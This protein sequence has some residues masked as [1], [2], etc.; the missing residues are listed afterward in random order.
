M[1]KILFLPHQ[2]EIQVK[3]KEV[4]LRAAME[5]GVHINAS[6]GGAGVCGK[7]R[8]L[9]EEGQV[10]GGISEKLSKEDLEKGYRQACLA[11]VVSDLV[12]RVPVESAIDAEVLNLAAVPRKTARIQEMNLD[13]LKEK[14]LF[15]PPVEKKYLELIPPSA[16]DNLPDTTRLLSFLKLVHD[17]HRLEVDLS[18]L[19]KIPDV[20]REQDFKVTAVLAR[21]VREKD[22]RTRIINVQPGD[23]TDHNYAIAM[24]IGTTTIYGQLLNLRTGD[25]LAQYGDFNGQISYGEDVISRIVYAEKPGG[26]EKLHQVVIETVNKIIL[27][28]FRHAR[29]DTEAVSTITLAG[30]TTMTQLFL[31]IN[32]RYIRRSPYVPASTLFPPIR[33]VDLGLA[34]GD[35]VTALFYP[36]LS[37]YVGGDIV[38]GVMGSGMYRSEALALFMDIGTNA[39]IV[40]GNKDWLACAACSAGP[41]FEGGGIR[42]GMRATKGAIEDFSIDPV[43][44]E[45]MFITIGNVKPKGICGSGLISVVATLLETGVISNDGKFNRDLKTPRVRAVD[46][47]WEYVLAFKDET[48]IDRDITLS[49]PDIDNL[50]RA[51]GA[52][53]SGCMTLLEEVG[54]S[55]KDVEQ[56]YLAGGFGSYV[57]LEK[58]MTIGLLPETDPDKVRYVGNG[59]LMG[60]KMSALTNRIRRD[61]V[62]VTRKM[63]NFELSET[64]SYMDHYIAALF[65]PHT[66]LEHFPRLKTRLEARKSLRTG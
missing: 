32:P 22:G 42:F 7:C 45:P 37:S 27:R 57:D 40:I 44:L 30:N 29:I 28:L 36:A 46:G 60:A 23:T 56:I 13:Q 53:F 66:D 58:A 15:V 10:E 14:G 54:L 65:L 16:Q 39:E 49:E 2:K 1:H 5:A 48:Q 21:P 12:I 43:T 11:A 64:T 34:V 26:L 61:V 19:R 9:I 51:K 50:I 18:V 4:L 17:E 33:A 31:K 25:V 3:D 63:T 52:L 8:V 24:D 6:C 35:H 38:S 55:I 47:I 20:L 62:E 59:S 41:A